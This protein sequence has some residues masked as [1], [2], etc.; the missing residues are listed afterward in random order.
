MSWLNLKFKGSPPNVSPTVR[1]IIHPTIW[2][3]DRPTVRPAIGLTCH[4]SDS[5]SDG[6]SVPPSVCP[7]ER[8]HLTC[9]TPARLWPVSGQASAR[10]WD[11]PGDGGSLDAGPGPRV[12]WALNQTS[13]TISRTESIFLHILFKLDQYRCR[14]QPIEFCNVSDIKI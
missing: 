9:Q 6:P 8:D 12:F 3:S 13:A 4:L 7:T 2:P 11:V 1:A 14:N 10:P 5:S